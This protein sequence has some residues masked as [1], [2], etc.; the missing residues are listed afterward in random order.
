MSF[1]RRKQRSLSWSVLKHTLDTLKHGDS[2]RQQ[3]YRKY[4]HPQPDP[5]A[6]YHGLDLL[7]V[8]VSKL[9]T[10]PRVHQIQTTAASKSRALQQHV[11][12]FTSRLQPGKW[13]SRVECD[14]LRELSKTDS[15]H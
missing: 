5:L 7:T 11:T 8:D 9:A 13:M 14:L 10:S 3:L 4:L 1:A 12:P 15:K 6:C 2:A